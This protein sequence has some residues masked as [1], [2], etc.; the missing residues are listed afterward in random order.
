MEKAI[1]LLGLTVSYSGQEAVND[2]NITVNKGEFLGLI[3]PNGGGKTTVLNSILGLIP[4]NSGKIEISGKK[5]KNGRRLIGYVP[6]T[7]AVDR[8]FP[9]TVIETVLSA[10]LN[11]GLHPF[12]H[13]SRTQKEKACK[14]LE[15]LGLLEM[16]N[17]P[18]GAL[19]G[20]EFQKLLIAR[21]LVSDPEI[22]LLDEPVSNIDEIS[23]N[24]IYSILKRL[25]RDGKTI[26]MVTHDMQSLSS[27]FSRV[28]YINRTVLFDGL[29]SNY[30]TEKGGFFNA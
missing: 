7:S 30:L 20:G 18:I 23:R 11:S 10:F 29:P 24:E 15:I 19:S 27:L 28:I 21:A 5:I 22:L 16:R 8:D 6:Q 12:K 26:I 13:F 17:K 25:N 3:G 2:I 1:S 4:K 9:I 14:T